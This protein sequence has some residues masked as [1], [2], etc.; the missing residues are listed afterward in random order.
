MVLLTVLIGWPG[1][2]RGQYVAVSAGRIFPQD[3]SAPPAAG[4][5]GGP[6]RSEFSSSAML[7][8]DA[9]IGFLPLIGAGLHYSFSRP[10]LLLRRPDSFGSSAVV[11]LASHTLTFDVSLHTPAFSGFRLYGLVGVGFSRFHLDVKKQVEVPFPGG[12]P[13]NLLAPVFAYGAGI[14]RSLAPFI[15]WKLEARDDISPIPKDL[16]GPQGAWHRP[17]VS[18][19]IIIG[20]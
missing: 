14:E 7:S 20:R 10:E 13:V 12:A 1:L 18:A 16:F 19:G 8:V 17:Q 4:S 5:V 15:R 9:G 2:A 11:E 6:A 3:L